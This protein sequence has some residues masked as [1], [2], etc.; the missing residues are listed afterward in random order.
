M[1]MIRCPSCGQRTLDV[2]SQCP[3]CGHVLL[4]NPLETSSRSDL[5]SC[6]RC[7]KHIDR[8]AAVCPFCGHHVQRARKLTAVGWGLGALAL[9]T[10]AAFGAYRAGYLGGS[11]PAPSA[12]GQAAP[13]ADSPVPRALP[14][15]A[16]TIPTALPIVVGRASRPPT[17]AAPARDSVVQE[18]DRSPATSLPPLEVRWTADWVN[19][20]EDRSIDS[21]V[22]RVLAPGRPVSVSGMRG[23]WWEYYEAGAMRGYIANSVLGPQP[24]G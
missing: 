7:Q 10:A 1:V 24:P 15:R 13:V 22:V 12:A 2:A 9:A 6:R 20:R 23:G 3:K 4:Q 11:A 21:P 8:R 14:V 19:V 16:D 17:P 18:P 5:I